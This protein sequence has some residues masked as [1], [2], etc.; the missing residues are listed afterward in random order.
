MKNYSDSKIPRLFELMEERGVRGSDLT[1]LFG[2]SSGNISNWKT[3][4]NLPSSGTLCA[5]ADYL[6]TTPEY[7]RGESD[8]KNK[9]TGVSADEL[10]EALKKVSEIASTLSDEE[11]QKWIDFGEMIIR[12]RKQ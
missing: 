6:G 3:G 11:K 12:S 9:P 10:D 5:I 8:E 2:V 1:R 7:L 4:K